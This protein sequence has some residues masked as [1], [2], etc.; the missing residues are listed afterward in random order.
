MSI[1][2]KRVGY[3]NEPGSFFDAFLCAVADATGSPRPNVGDFPFRHVEAGWALT[4]EGKI[5]RD[6]VLAHLK[7]GRRHEAYF[8]YHTC[9]MCGS[10]AGYQDLT[11]GTYVWPEG[12]AHY[13]EAHGVKPPQDFIDHVMSKA[14][15]FVVMYGAPW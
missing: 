12:Y 3:W 2:L 9:L 6:I 15:D 1:E 7:S 4:R 11:D 14:G 13:I 10:D 5:E 8:G